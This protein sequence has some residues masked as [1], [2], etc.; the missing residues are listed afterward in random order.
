MRIS[1]LARVALMAAVVTVA[2]F[3]AT[4]QAHSSASP[5]A[6]VTVTESGVRISFRVPNSSGWERFS[7]EPTRTSPEGP[8]SLNKSSVGSQGAEAI[9]YWTSFPDGDYADPCARLLGRSVGKSASALAASVSTAPGT[10]LVKGPLNVRLGGRPAQ[11]VVLRVRKNTGCD[12]G[13]FYSWRDGFAGALWPTT[14]A[15]DTIQVWIIPVGGTRLFI[16]AATSPQANPK[17]KQEVKQ[18]VKSIRFDD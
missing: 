13:F 14:S 3:T 8:I 6:K 9:V 1:D 11:H 10:R 17:L 4:A 16:Q 2:G 12:P 5:G 15:G 18:I 7:T